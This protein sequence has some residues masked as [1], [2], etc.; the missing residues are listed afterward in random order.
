[1]SVCVR[2]VGGEI[3]DIKILVSFHSEI[4]VLHVVDSLKQ[5]VKNTYLRNIHLTGNSEF[6][7]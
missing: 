7:L 4:P 2:W 3:C 1:M 5:Q 6:L